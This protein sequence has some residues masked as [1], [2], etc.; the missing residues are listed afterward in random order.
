MEDEPRDKRVPIM[1]TES[2][3]ALID[4]WRFENRVATR[5]EAVR[6][7]VVAG[8]VS[9]LKGIDRARMDKTVRAFL[10]EDEVKG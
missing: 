3:V 9:K 2:E 4:D 7:L 5:S 10:S 6:R 1:L 8:L